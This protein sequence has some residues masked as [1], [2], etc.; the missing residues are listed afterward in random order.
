MEI[1][2]RGICQTLPLIIG[3]LTA[4]SLAQSAKDQPIQSFA[5]PFDQMTPHANGGNTA[6]PIL[7]GV[8]HSGAHLEV[9]ETVLAPGAMPH[10]PHHHTHEELFLLSRGTIEVTIAGKSTTIGPG[11]AAFI[12][13]GE[14][15]GV[16]NTGQEPA[17]YFV[18]AIGL[19][20]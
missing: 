8:T 3:S 9:H 18:V 17:Q 1:T 16:R 19:E 13:S 4:D 7:N 12:L 11:S 5:L 10:P 15:H 20:T 2:R 6:R 14:E